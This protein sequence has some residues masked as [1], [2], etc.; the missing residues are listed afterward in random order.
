L[1]VAIGNVLN[2]FNGD[3]AGTGF[4]T[5]RGATTFA[6]YQRQRAKIIAGITALAPDIMG[7]TEVEN[8]GFGPAS[9]LADLVAGLNAAAPAGKTYAFVDASGVEITTDLI[10][11]AFIYRT[12]TVETVGAP[13]MLSDPAF[14][15]VARNPLAQTF[16]QRSTGERL[17][18]CINHFRAKGSAATGA[19]N[20]DSGDGQGTNNALRVQ[21]ANAVTA[22]LATDPT[23][24][25]DA[26]F[27]VIGDL[28]A[29]AK[30]DPITAF[31][32]AGY[33]NL[34]EAFEGEGGYSYAFNGEFGHLD[35]A[36]ATPRLAEQVVGT[37]TWHANADE[38]VYYDYNTENK[39]AAQQ[40][41]NTDTPYRYADHDPVVIGVSLHPEY[42]APV[43]T[44]QPA[45]QTVT[46]GNSV[47]FTVAAS[48]Y[49]AP[50]FQWQ[51]NGFDIGGATS[52]TLTLNHVTT[53]T[54]GTYTAIA[55][56]I[57]GSATSD[58]A[59]LKVNKAAATVI[60]GNLTQSHDGTPKPVTVT[61]T[62]AGLAVSVTYDGSSTPPSNVGSYAVVATV[63]DPDYAGSATGTLTIADTAAPVF[64]SLTARP[65]VLWPP[66]GQ[67]E[68]VILRAVVTDAVDPNPIT[69]IIAV[70]SN[71][72]THGFTLFGHHFFKDWDH[73]FS[74]DWVITG[75]LTLKLR[76]ERSGHGGDRVYTITVESRDHSGNA[77]T[78][79]VT[80]TVPHRR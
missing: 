17:T 14:N 28:N 38:P 80:V 76:A 20:A 64:T 69:R 18:V 34:T 77:S 13:A 75:P 1:H 63:I 55:T 25:G 67:F 73:H 5:A 31:R 40:A 21:E 45:S 35:H 44:L 16:R 50:S 19:G 12:E 4:P 15:N 78:R 33:V 54:A 26:D 30:E 71:E 74:R 61:T 65:N 23:V 68:T 49:P 9:A 22:W 47:T 41:I 56:N 42:A 29:Y 2:F 10:H 48:G 52:S 7:L 3:G 66:N 8:D 43:F 79:T 57:I 72:S 46:V 6:E 70:S 11:V 39:D 60:L 27:L 24:S 53:A 36:L 37:S 62:P 32:T 58:S 59:T 51:R